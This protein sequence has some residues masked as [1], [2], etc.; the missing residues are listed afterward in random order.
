[1]AN[2]TQSQFTALFSQGV[3]TDWRAE[4]DAFSGEWVVSF[5]VGFS[6]CYLLDVRR[7]EVKRFKS[8]DS[9]LSALRLVGFQ[10][11]QFKSCA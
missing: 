7:K 3:V 11:S 5:L 6:W 8:F 4:F 2:M 10:I 9:V 1:M